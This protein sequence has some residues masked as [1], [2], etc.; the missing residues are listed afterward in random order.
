MK[1]IQRRENIARKKR[2]QR[3]K[4]KYIEKRVMNGKNKEREKTIKK[5]NRQM[6][7]IEYNQKYKQ[8]RF[9]N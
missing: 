7:G 9:Y 2:V 5:Y 8:M 6:Y 4:S 1:R 3:E